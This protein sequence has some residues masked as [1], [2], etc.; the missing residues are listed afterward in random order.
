MK[1]KTGIA[2]MIATVLLQ[3]SLAQAANQDQKFVTQAGQAGLF[4]IQL[5]QLAVDVS[6]NDEVIAYGQELVNDHTAAND[7]LDLIAAANGFEAPTDLTRSQQKQLDR[8]ANLSGAKFDR[9]FAKLAV[10]SHRRGIKVLQKES[11]KGQDADLQAFAD[12]KLPVEQDHLATGQQ[13][14]LDLKNNP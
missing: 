11:V 7:Q 10:A 4:E 3:S 2:A 9:A 5:G 12:D 14:A 6:T 8:L 13:L 1:I